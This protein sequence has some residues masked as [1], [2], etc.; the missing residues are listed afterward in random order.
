MLLE[1]ENQPLLYEVTSPKI[2]I[3]TKFPLLGAELQ[4][5]HYWASNVSPFT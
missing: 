4:K 5:G 2:H 3:F 1:N